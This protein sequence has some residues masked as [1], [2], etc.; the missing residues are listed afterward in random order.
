MHRPY[1][2][3][4]LSLAIVFGG[5]LLPSVRTAAQAG[6]TGRERVAVLRFRGPRSTAVRRQLVGLIEERAQLIGR[7][8]SAR[9]ARRFRVR[10]GRA[11]RVGDLAESLG[12]TRVVLGRCTRRSVAVRWYVIDEEGNVEDEVLMVAGLSAA[13]LRPV[14]DRML[15]TPEVQPERAP[16]RDAPPQ[17]VVA[18]DPEVPRE[19][20]VAIE[21]AEESTL[22][23]DE[24][25]S[26]PEATG[27]GSRSSEPDP[28]RGGPTQT[29]SSSGGLVRAEPWFVLDAGLAVRGRYAEVS[30][31]NGQSLV[32]RAPLIGE[33]VSQ[34]SIRPL[35]PTEDPW[36][37][38]FV[39]RGYA[40]VALA[41]GGD[42]PGGAIG[43]ESYGGGGHLG[44]LLSI[45]DLVEIGPLIGLG[46]QLF[47][48]DD[49]AFFPTSEY[50]RFDALVRASL[51]LIS[52]RLSIAVE[53]GYQRTMTG[54]PLA[55]EFGQSFGGNGF[56]FEAE[57]SGSIVEESSVAFGWR[58]NF[59]WNRTGLTMGGT[60]RDVQGQGGVEEGVRG[61]VSVALHVR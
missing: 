30:I 14:V 47:A 31:P 19:T 11:S 3:V 16:E 24:G 49:N 9:A 36:L 56:V 13:E 15:G 29:S 12:A 23:Q 55:T 45:D 44:W 7:R 25:Q 28:D 42:S 38:G 26:E 50:L 2:R 51:P 53:A 27:D 58:A 17:R 57:A 52:R 10:L 39:L 32:H 60:A 33:F 46:Y 6:R 37:S 20:E 21:Q 4:G 1:L 35:A 34:L 54:G 22:T 43:G 61:M 48:L 5:I 59:R 41:F 8:Q 40:Q 18:R